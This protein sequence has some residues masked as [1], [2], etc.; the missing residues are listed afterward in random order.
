MSDLAEFTEEV[1]AFLNDKLTPE[2]RHYGEAYPGYTSPRPIAEKWTQILNDQGWSVP[3]W[4]VE[5]GGT[6]WSREKIMT[7]KREMIL[8]HAP[9][10]ITS[11]EKMVGP[12]VIEFGTDKQK[13]SILPSIRDGSIWWAQGYSEPN[14]GSDLSSLQTKAVSDGNDYIIN[15]TKIWTSHAHKCEKIF[16]LVRTSN[17]GKP[18][19]GIS[20]L[21]FDLDLPGIEIRPIRTFGGEHEF[22]EIFFTDVR[23]PKSSLLGEENGGWTVAKHLLVN[24]RTYSYATIIHNYLDRIRSFVRRSHGSSDALLLDGTDVMKKLASAEM[25]LKCL[26]AMED[27]ALKMVRTDMAEASA[28]ASVN[29]IAGSKLQQ[30]VTELGA[31]VLGYYALPLQPRLEE[32]G[33]LAELI[34]DP[35][36][37]TALAVADYFADRAIT[38]AGGTREIQKNIIATRKLGL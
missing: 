21:L 36:T 20:F 37:H 29:K 1:R 35:S 12:V 30:R 6:D 28:L 11:G 19:A 10:L 5:Y 32:P 3:G 26:M 23:V 15:G 34:G 33:Q 2:L 18:Q 9:R 13:E 38:I 22:N 7:L 16:C 27:K 25:D 4:P 24:E 17:E 31:E 14:A 8:A